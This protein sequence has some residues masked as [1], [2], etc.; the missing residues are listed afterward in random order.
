MKRLLRITHGETVISPEA[1]QTAF[2]RVAEQCNRV[3]ISVQRAP[4]ADG[5]FAIIRP[6]D[7]LQGRAKGVVPVMDGTGV[8]DS[9]VKRNLKDVAEKLS[10]PY[11]PIPTPEIG[12]G[13]LFSETRYNLLI[14]TITLILSS[15][16]VIGLGLYSHFQIKER[17]HSYEPESIL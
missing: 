7:L 14:V 11:A 16:A 1:L 10:L 6:C 15:G 9:L 17:M 13:I 5:T 12:E 4:D 8:R 3:P 2:L